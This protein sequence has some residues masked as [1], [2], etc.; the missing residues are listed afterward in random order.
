MS[1][2]SLLKKIRRIADTRRLRKRKGILIAVA[3]VAMVAWATPLGLLLWARIRILTSIPRTAI[4]DDTLAYAPRV[5]LPTEL[6]PA[7]PGSDAALRDPFFVDQKVFPDPR[8]VAS[9]APVS[10]PRASVA[11][12]TPSEE[13]PTL[14]RDADLGV[15]ERSSLELARLSAESFRVQSAGAGLVTAVVD[16]RARRIGDVLTSTDGRAFTLVKV[17]DRGIVLSHESHEITV[18]MPAEVSST[19]ESGIKSSANA[20]EVDGSSRGTGRPQ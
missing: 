11:V 13:L 3:S 18:R 9:P 20:G 15:T 17:I 14:K 19:S 2:V 12:A 5:E 7:L 16:D 6:D 1:V 4:A 10:A 8:T